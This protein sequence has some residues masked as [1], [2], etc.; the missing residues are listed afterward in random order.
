[1]L[2]KDAGLLLP[3]DAATYLGLAQQTL[4][5]WRYR[6]VGPEYLKV[7]G[8]IRYRME[9]LEAFVKQAR[10]LCYSRINPII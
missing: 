5:G 9:D 10:E 1:M 2:D 6:K 4:A 8:R 7:C 3:K